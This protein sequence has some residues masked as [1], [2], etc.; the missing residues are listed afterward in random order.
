MQS[1]FMNSEKLRLSALNHSEPFS[2][3]GEAGACPTRAS[4][5]V[6]VD[7]AETADLGLRLAFAS[8]PEDQARGRPDPS[9]QQKS[10]AERARRDDRKVGAK[11]GADV[12]CFADALA[13]RLRCAGQLLS[14]GF[15][16]TP[17]LL[18][19]ARVATGHRSS[20]PRWSTS[21]RGTPV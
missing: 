2:F 1:S 11:L 6:A 12:R 3:S 16:V 8:T 19:G 15:D 10:D 14:L 20:V 13:Q 21:P 17:D 18:D 7:K 5:S 4:R 9:G